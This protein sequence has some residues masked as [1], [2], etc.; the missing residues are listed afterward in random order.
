M[1]IREEFFARALPDGV[2][3][4]SAVSEDWI[5]VA[6]AKFECPIRAAVN[7][8]RFDVGGM[9]YSPDISVVEPIGIVC[10]EGFNRCFDG[11]IAMELQPY[12]TPLDVCFSRIRV[13]EVP[14]FQIGPSGYF[15]NSVFSSIWYHTTN[16]GAGVWHRPGRDNFFFN[17]IAS[18]SEYCPPP[19]SEGNIDWLIPLAWAEDDATS[20][21]DRVGMMANEYHQIFSLDAQGGL[22]IDKFSQWIKCSAEGRV[23][24]SPDIR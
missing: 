13:M 19:I 6:G 5:A 14:T 16:R 2:A 24:A 17:D 1:G 8:I 9:S 4:V 7:G 12:V 20:I 18:F 22:R 10:S 3:V 21:D 11:C 15:T 23:T